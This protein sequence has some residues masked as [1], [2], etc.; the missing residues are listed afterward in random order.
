[1]RR[2]TVEEVENSGT[3][4]TAWKRLYKTRDLQEQDE[5]MKGV[6][7]QS[8]DTLVYFRQMKKAKTGNLASRS[9]NEFRIIDEWK[10]SHPL[11]ATNRGDDVHECGRGRCTF[12]KNE[13]IYICESTGN[14]HFCNHQCDDSD[15]ACSIDKERW[16][17][18][19]DEE[20]ENEHHEEDPDERSLLVRCFEFGYNCSSLSE[21]SNALQFVGD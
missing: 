8:P 16:K 1:V 18:A 2:W 21:A 19:Q 3:T 6:L 12:Y 15:S 11:C 4:E 14:V 17:Y 20:I 13:N 10:R 5:F 9:R 7:D